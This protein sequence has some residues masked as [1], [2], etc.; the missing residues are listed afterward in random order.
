MTRS[1]SLTQGRT[2][3]A[4]VRAAE[5]ALSQPSSMEFVVSE[6]TGG[7]NHWTIVAASG[8]IL[9]QCASFASHEEAKQAARIMHASAAL[10]SLE[11]RTSDTPPID[12][13]ARRATR[14]HATRPGRRMGAGR[15][16]E[17]QRQPGPSRVS[18]TMQ[19]GGLKDATTPVSVSSTSAPICRAP[20]LAG[21]ENGDPARRLALQLG[22]GTPA[23]TAV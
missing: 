15:T 23:V 1:V 4:A 7:S 10:A 12:L 20:A 16:G 13:V 14:L 5:T 6:D 19:P 22:H 9:V 8:E 21:R 11:R 3:N 17:R 2:A 18:L